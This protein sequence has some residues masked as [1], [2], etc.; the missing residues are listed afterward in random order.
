MR[1]GTCAALLAVALAGCA[2]APETVPVP[3]FPGPEAAEISSAAGA[4]DV[5]L[6]DDCEPVMPAADLVALLGL[7]LGSVAVRTTVGVPEPSVGRV[8]RVA[9]RYTGTFGRARGATVLEL[10]AGR[11][12]DDASATRQW[13]LNAAAEQ[14]SRR[15]VPLGSADAMVIERPDGA[16]LTVVNRDVALTLTLPTG[17]PRPPGRSPADTLIDLALRVLAVVT[18]AQVPDREPA[19]AG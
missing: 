8:E 14:G 2:G 10:N 1:R 5:G 4:P 17:A 11:Y 16:V 12:V 19:V 3:T 6:P 18:P 9:C 15:S 13:R 7:P